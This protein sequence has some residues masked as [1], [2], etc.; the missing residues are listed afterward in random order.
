MNLIT[1]TKTDVLYVN[2][3]I[4]PIYGTKL[5]VIKYQNSENGFDQAI[6]F[7]EKLGV[8][9]EEDQLT[10]RTH[11]GYVFQEKVKAGLITFFFLNCRED[12]RD[13]LHDTIAHEMYHVMQKVRKY[14]G[15]TEFDDDNNEHIA[16]LTGHI[17]KHVYDIVYNK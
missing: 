3:S 17:T 16:Y 12:Y 9:M 11:F 13:D 4:V 8:N 6:E 14:H 7:C 2:L 10:A 1:E 15:L 5:C